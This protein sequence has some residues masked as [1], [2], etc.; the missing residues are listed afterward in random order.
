MRLCRFGVKIA[1]TRAGR[2]VCQDSAVIAPHSAFVR[3]ATSIPM[4][5]FRSPRFAFAL[6]RAGGLGF[7][8]C[9]GAANAFAANAAPAFSRER[10]AQSTK[11]HTT[12]LA[13]DLLEG[14]GTGT[15]GHALAGR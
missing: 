14:R 3:V 1:S 7:A 9:A 4:P 2:E 15:R 10:A 13:D 12:F 8:I 6:F 5:S 11:A